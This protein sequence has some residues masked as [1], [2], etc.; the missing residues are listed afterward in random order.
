MDVLHVKLK[1]KYHDE[2]VSNY[3]DY[4]GVRDVYQYVAITLQN[5]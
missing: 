3:I 4:V 5:E 2:F 1:T